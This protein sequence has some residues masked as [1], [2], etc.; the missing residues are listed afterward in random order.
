VA[1]DN[2]VNQRLVTRLLEKRGHQ[3]TLAATGQQAVDRWSEQPFDAVLMDVQM[4]D[5]DGLQ[6]TGVIR[7]RE[8]GT[9]RH[10]PIIALTAHAMKGDRERCLGA[11]MDNYITKPIN[12]AEL[13]AVLQSAVAASRAAEPAPVTS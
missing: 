10:T 6:A 8:K 1:E 5:M 2:I 3:V 12:S 9:G 11:G 13:M 7:E 4:P